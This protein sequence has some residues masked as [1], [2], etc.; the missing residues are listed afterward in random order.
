ME[1]DSDKTPPKKPKK[2]P[3]KKRA[4]KKVI[5]DGPDFGTDKVPSLSSLAANLKGMEPAGGDTHKQQSITAMGNNMQEHL[6]CFILIGYTVDGDPVNMTYAPTAK[7]MDS[8]GT[9]LQRYIFHSGG[10]GF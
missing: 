7:D 8:L 10:G 2:R 4:K 1:E 6:S 3:A 9:G 5:E